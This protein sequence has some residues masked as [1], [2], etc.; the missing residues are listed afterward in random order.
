MFTNQEWAFGNNRINKQEQA[1]LCCFSFLRL[2]FFFPPQIQKY[3]LILSISYFCP[4]QYGS[5]KFIQGTLV[6]EDRD[7]NPCFL[8]LAKRVGSCLELFTFSDPSGSAFKP[9]KFLQQNLQPN[10][11]VFYTFAVK[12]EAE[13]YK[14]PAYSSQ[15][16]WWVRT[17]IIRIVLQTDNMP[18]L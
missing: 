8:K 5:C 3:S 15:H 1:M 2:F 12:S 9:I 6:F 14:Y 16:I 11:F 13:F 7:N 10:P 17:L 18:K 4:L